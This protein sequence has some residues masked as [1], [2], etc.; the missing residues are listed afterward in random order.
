[1][2]SSLTM[3]VPRDRFDAHLRDPEIELM[4]DELDIRM[5]NRDGL[6]DVLDADGSGQLD[7][8]DHT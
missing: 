1:M 2:I 3:P 5:V 8:Q 7:P 6:F 4:L